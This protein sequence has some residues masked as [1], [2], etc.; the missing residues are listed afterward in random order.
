MSTPADIRSFEIARG[1]GI[2]RRNAATA[3]SMGIVL[4][5]AAFGLSGSLQREIRPMW[6]LFGLLAGLAYA[7]V[8]EYVLHRF[9]LHWGNGFLVQ[10]HA[11]HHDS[12]GAPEEARYVNFATSPLVVILLF[13]LNALPIFVLQRALGSAL[14]RS[15]HASVAIGIFAGF[16]LYYVAYEEIHWR[17]H[18]GRLPGWLQSARRHHMLHHGGFE[19]HYN[20]FLPV[21]DWIF[22]RSEWKRQTIR[23]R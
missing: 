16:T 21:F 2:K 22:H 15:L 10:R 23:T 1:L 6:I 7:N 4:A 9:L 3:V 5:F 20:V 8:F 17:I 12:A 19:G 14:K 13:A 18:L 11:L